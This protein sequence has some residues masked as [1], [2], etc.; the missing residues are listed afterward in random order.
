M[1]VLKK[2]SVY[3]DNAATT[4]ICEEA[5]QAMTE[6]MRDYGNPSSSHAHGRKVRGL[7][8]LARKSIAKDL[9]CDPREIYF[10][11]GGTEADNMTLRCAVREGVTTIITSALEHKAV[12]QTA[13]DLKNA[14]GIELHF[15]K[16]K[17]KGHIDLEDLERLLKGRNS[18]TTS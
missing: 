11:S 5:I 12:L 13:K 10:T 2:T 7:I 15:V 9:N 14:K 3:L 17:K 1:T 16:L 6:V 8:E 18:V 4:P